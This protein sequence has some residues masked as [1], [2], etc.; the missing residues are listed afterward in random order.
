MASWDLLRELDNL[1]REIDDAF[2][3]AG[4]NRPYGTAFLSPVNARRSL[5][6]NLR[7]TQMGGQ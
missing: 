1:R 4:M 3:G 6:V 7:A 2:R 5:L